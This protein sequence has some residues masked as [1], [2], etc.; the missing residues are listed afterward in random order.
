MVAISNLIY[1]YLS[2]NRRI[3]VPTLGTLLVKGDHQTLLFSQFL[4][5]DDG[6]LRGLIVQQGLSEEEA[7]AQ[8]ESFVEQIQAA[9]ERGESYELPPMGRLTKSGDVILL[10][11]SAP[12]ETEDETEDETVVEQVVEPEPEPEVDEIEE[13]DEQKIVDSILDSLSS[14]ELSVDDAASEVVP[15]ST[16]ELTPEVVPEV[17][18]ELTNNPQER[19]KYDVWLIAA[20]TAGAF[21]LFALLYGVMVEWQI[22]NI[23]FG[24]AID[25]LLYGI[26]G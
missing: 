2:E 3:T 21:A 15:E 6:V 25:N 20:I 26:F 9:F 23:S 14:F 19:P 16:P 8:L 7:T 10:D 18:S 22:G 11:D 17:A 1:D 24:R 5:G 12:E 13:E 4:K